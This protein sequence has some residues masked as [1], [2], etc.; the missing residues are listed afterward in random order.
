MKRLLKLV[1]IACLLTISMLT[2]LVMMIEI[3][4]LKESD[5]PPKISPSREKVRKEIERQQEQVQLKYERQQAREIAEETRRREKQ[6]EIAEETRRRLEKWYV[7]GTLHKTNM[8]EWSSASYQNKL[9]TAADFVVGT[10]LSEGVDE[11]SIDIEGDV[12]PKAFGL[13]VALDAANKDGIA[14]DLQVA[15]VVAALHIIMY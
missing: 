8:K 6:Q 12:K 4:P 15:E 2:V 5:H 1:G 13:M 10:M 9:A 7:G 14:N 3:V 11:L